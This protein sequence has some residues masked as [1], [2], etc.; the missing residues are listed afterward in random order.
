MLRVLVRDIRSNS[1][2]PRPRRTENRGPDPKPRNASED[3]RQG[4]GTGGVGEGDLRVVNP[5]GC[6]GRGHRQTG[7]GRRLGEGPLPEEAKEPARNGAIATGRPATGADERFPVERRRRE[8]EERLVP[9]RDAEARVV[10]A[11]V[12][13]SARP[14]SGWWPDALD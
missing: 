9:A 8:G 4:I 1:L 10:Q 7:K 14:G 11:L 2:A 12:L 5:D 13:E 6:R 3:L